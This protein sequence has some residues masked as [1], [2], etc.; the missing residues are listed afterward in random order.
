LRY[1][2]KKRS[3]LVQVNSDRGKDWVAIGATPEIRRHLAGCTI[4]DIQEFASRRIKVRQLTAKE[5]RK[6]SKSALHGPKAKLL[7]LGHG[8]NPP[9]VELETH[10]MLR[11]FGDARMDYTSILAKVASNAVRY[12]VA[13]LKRKR[14]VEIATISEELYVAEFNKAYG[15]RKSS[16]SF[17]A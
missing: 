1:D 8:E 12:E 10:R 6:Y 3:A 2:A 9:W 13:H 11:D 5:I 15:L 7:I 16:P 17:P 4:P 14:V